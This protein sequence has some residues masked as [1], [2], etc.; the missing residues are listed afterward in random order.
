MVEG[1]PM[2]IAAEIQQQWQTAPQI[3]LS[4][5]LSGAQVRYDGGHK[6]DRFITQILG[7]HVDFTL[8]CPEMGIGLGV[9]RATLHLEVHPEQ[10]AQ[11]VNSQNGQ[12]LNQQI[13]HYAQQQQPQLDPLCG[14]IFKARSPSCG[15][16]RVKVWPANK[17]ANASPLH[18][19]GQ[20]RF[21]HYVQQHY[22]LLPLEEE[23]RLKDQDLREMFL[24][25]VYLYHAWQK[26][27]QQPLSRARLQALHAYLKLS[28]MA[29]Q[30][31]L[32]A[33]LGSQLAAPD[34][35]HLQQCADTYFHQVMQALTRP[36]SRQRHSN[37]LMHMLGYFRPHLS[38]ADRQECHQC[39]LDYQQGLLPRMA[40]LTLLRHYLR[41][42]PI[43]YLAQQH[44]LQPYPKAL[45]L[46]SKQ[47]FH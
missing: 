1:L 3:G 34:K 16:E 32:T 6:H 5:C 26:F 44:Y 20:G 15:L 47:V 40:P 9:P 21:A 23:G 11:L 25:R 46:C 35:Q 7:P 12:G 42:H 30:P 17:P 18:H 33:K 43:P 4:Q 29:H 10:A 14:F 28:L 39:I 38:T 27:I 24:Q 22:P 36:V 31:S 13:Q 41:Q 37:V 2:Q 8:F 45:L 19:R